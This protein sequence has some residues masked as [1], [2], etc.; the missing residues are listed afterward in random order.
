M[1]REAARTTLAIGVLWAVT[2]VAIFSLGCS[3]DEE[4]PKQQVDLSPGFARF[5]LPD[6]GPQAPAKVRPKDDPWPGDVDASFRRPFQVMMTQTI[7]HEAGA[8]APP[9]NPDDAVL[10]RARVSA[11][12]CFSSLAATPDSPPE[13]SAHIVFTVIPTGTVSNAN[14]SS[15]DTSEEQ[16]VQCLREE[17]LSTTFSDNGGGPLRTY[18]IDVRVIAKRNTAGR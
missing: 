1:N 8:V 7:V 5:S 15:A 18:S 10:E 3:R 14:V 6:S 12:R 2:T 16:V 11:G 4:Q 9:V 13:R 17:A